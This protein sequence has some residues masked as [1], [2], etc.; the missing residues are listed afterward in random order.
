MEEEIISLLQVQKHLHQ[1]KGV[2]IIS[3]TLMLIAVQLQDVALLVMLSLVVKLVIELN[4][5]FGGG[6]LFSLE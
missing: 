1:E 5:Y 6:C 2:I 3:V 4:L